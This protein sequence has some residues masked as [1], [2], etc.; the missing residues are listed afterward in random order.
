MEHELTVQ[1]SIWPTPNKNT[2]L[3]IRAEALEAREDCGGGGFCT[4]LQGKTSVY[5]EENGLGF[6]NSP[7]AGVP[8]LPSIRCVNLSPSRASRAW[9]QRAA[10]TWL[11]PAL[12]P[13]PAHR[14]HRGAAC[15][16]V[17]CSCP[18]ALPR[19]LLPQVQVPPLALASQPAA[20]LEV[21]HFSKL[22]A[23]HTFPSV[24]QLSHSPRTSFEI[25]QTS[26]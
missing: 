12:M 17:S 2:I 6:R 14:P 25:S 15:H 21:S 13:A 10:W 16:G 7:S 11:S 5:R 8:A 4:G 26:L 19:V 18:R 9:E 20:L 3:G 22:L 23:A 24:S 1:I